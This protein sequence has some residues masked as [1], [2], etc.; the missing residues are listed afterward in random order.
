MNN[1]KM[2]ESIRTL[3]NNDNISPTR[4]EEILGFSQGLISRWKNKTPSVDRIIDIADYFHVSLDEVVG[5]NI[6][7]NDNYNS[8]DDIIIPLIQMTDDKEIKWEY[9]TDYENQKIRKTSYEELF[10]LYCGDEI[11]IYKCKYYD[12][13]L[14][15]VVQYDLDQGIV[16]NLDIKLYLQPNDD[17]QPVR[18]DIY[19]E[20]TQEFWIKIREQ[21]IGIPDE[22]KAE[23]VKKQIFIDGNRSALNSMQQ[24]IENI[25]DNSND[26]DAFLSDKSIKKILSEGDSSELQQ[27]ISIFTDP[28]MMKAIKSVQKM[29]EYFS[30]IKSIKIDDNNS[31]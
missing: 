20:H 24:Y 30:D 9:I 7:A 31:K 29:I 1:E 23:N 21:F 17:S 18:Q 10:D 8:N 25:P 15:L 6:Y 12:S 28:K 22:W 3:C 16:E 11:E 19:E 5:R 13:Y 14:F 26:I 27:L 4:L 2:L